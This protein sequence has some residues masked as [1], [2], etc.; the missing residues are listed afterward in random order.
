VTQ[1][2]FQLTFYLAAPFWALMILAPRWPWTLRVVSSPLII[3]PA[4]AVYFVQVVPHFPQLWRAV[5]QPSLPAL[6]AFLAEPANTAA[7][8]AQLIAFDLFI[9]RWMYLDSRR[10]GIHPFVMS[11]LL[12]LTILLSPFGVLAFLAIRTVTARPQQGGRVQDHREHDHR[13]HRESDREHR[14]SVSTAS[15]TRSGEQ[16][17]GQ[18]V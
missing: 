8:W 4:L 18:H 11:P 16:R 7:I 9:G 14:E 5:S 1:T 15:A 3:V 17:G 6:Q 13:E 12:V 2:L 10:R